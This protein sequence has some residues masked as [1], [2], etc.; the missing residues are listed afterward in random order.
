MGVVVLLVH[1]FRNFAKTFLRQ[2][3]N[4]K[5]ALYC[6]RHVLVVRATKSG[7]PNRYTSC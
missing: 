3:S 1:R 7:L 6:W 4:N 5:P 2:L